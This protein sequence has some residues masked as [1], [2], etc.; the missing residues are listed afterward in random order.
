VVDVSSRTEPDVER[1]KQFKGIVS[2][3]GPLPLSA[4]PTLS[5]RAKLDT[6]VLLCQVDDDVADAAKAEFREVQVI[7]WKR[8]E[9][10]MPQN[11]DEIL[12]I[13]HFIAACLRTW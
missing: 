4:V 9:V 5:N 13:L 12:P 8:G 3:G 11:R 6:R 7:K 1:Q 10:A 2:I